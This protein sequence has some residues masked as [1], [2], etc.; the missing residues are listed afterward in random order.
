[1]N[2]SAC[3]CLEFCPNCRSQLRSQ[4]RQAT[5]L[6]RKSVACLSCLIWPR[7]G[8]CCPTASMSHMSHPGLKPLSNPKSAAQVSKPNSP[9]SPGLHASKSLCVNSASASLDVTKSPSL[10]DSR[11]RASLSLQAS[12]LPGL[13][14]SMSSSLQG[15][16]SYLGH[17]RSAWVLPGSPRAA[18]PAWCLSDLPGAAWGC[19]AGFQGFSVSTFPSFQ[20]SRSPSL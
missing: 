13:Q 8:Q 5:R 4:Y 7:V 20:I 15:S 2:T 6:D 17:V 19:L 9:T 14:V 10:Q 3:F 18:W 1:M 16:R 12:K 11:P